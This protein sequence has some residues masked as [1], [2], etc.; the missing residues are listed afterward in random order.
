MNQ[1]LSDL[2]AV[3]DGSTAA[4]KR[5]KYGREKTKNFDRERTKV[6]RE[7]T[8]FDR[9]KTKVDKEKAKIDRE[10][11]IRRAIRQGILAAIEHRICSSNFVKIGE[12]GPYNA[13]FFEKRRTEG[14][15]TDT[16]Y[17]RSVEV[18]KSL[19]RGRQSGT[20]P[21]YTSDM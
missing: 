1:L 12:N 21:Y 17:K 9:E 13:E 6:D 18:R 16:R 3:T 10:R 2:V 7:K 15:R 11:V 4:G 14:R 20:Y 8:E 5:Q 19:K